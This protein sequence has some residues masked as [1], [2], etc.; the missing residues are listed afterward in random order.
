MVKHS[1]VYVKIKKKFKS[2]KVGEIIV[3]EKID[4]LLTKGYYNDKNATKELLKRDGLHTGDIAKKDI[5]AT[6]FI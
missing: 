6:I 1:L 5:K 3:N 2:D 4:G